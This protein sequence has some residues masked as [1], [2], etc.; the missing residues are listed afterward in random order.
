MKHT[1][2]VTVD[3]KDFSGAIFNFE[4]EFELICFIKTCLST[5]N[6]RNLQIE[7]KQQE[8]K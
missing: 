3:E 5:S 2:R 4:N 1:Y 8:D 7:M 6:E